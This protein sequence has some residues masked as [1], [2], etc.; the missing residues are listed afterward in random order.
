MIRGGLLRMKVNFQKLNPDARG[1]VR[2]G[3]GD[4]GYDLSCLSRVVIPPMSRVQVHTGIAVEIPHGYYGRIAP[5]SGLA[6]KHGL[7][8]LG[9]VI[10]SGY[11]GEISVVLI[12]LNLPE[13][14]FTPDHKKNTVN[15]YESH[16]GSRSTIE[17]SHGS[18]IAQL[19]I[20]KYHDAE[21]TEVPDLTESVRGTDGFGSTGV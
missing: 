1:P 14:L 20:E 13:E 18:R 19:I 16:F 15:S 6:V 7:D 17:F 3:Y 2:G 12:N 11:R 9:G 10:D 21:W 4:A 8:V 5:R